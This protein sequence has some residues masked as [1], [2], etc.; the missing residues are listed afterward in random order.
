MEDNKYIVRYHSINDIICLEECINRYA[1]K[2]YELVSIT[3]SE[4]SHILIFK[5][6]I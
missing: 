2:G 1:N 5:K 4:L 6:N 3:N